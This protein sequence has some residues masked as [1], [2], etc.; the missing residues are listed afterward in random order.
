MKKILDKAA[1][2]FS[3][4]FYKGL[5]REQSIEASYD[6][7]YNSIQRNMPNIEI[8]SHIAERFRKI[9][10]LEEDVSKVV[11]EPLKIILKR[12]TVQENKSQATKLSVNISSEFEQEIIEEGNRKRY[13]D[14]LR[15]V[16]DRFGQTTI[17]RE[18]PISEFEYRQR[19]TL[20][21]KVQDFWI[22]GFLKPSLY[23]NTAVDKKDESPEQI[24]RPLDN[25][26]VIPFDIDQSYDELQQTDIIGQISDGKT[27]LILG[28]PGSGKTIALL[29]LAERLVE[30]TQKDLNERKQKSSK[31]IPV[32]LNLSSWGQKQQPLEEWLTIS[33][34]AKHR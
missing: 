8:V 25:L 30:Q 29:Q 3:V 13:Y 2:Y 15:D 32:V 22:E 18:K 10:V 16:L 5:V 31:P 12:K 9:E 34:P 14:K 21:N 7:G 33:P 4:G 6:W 24:L 1:Y 28:E 20:L 23:F 26:E 17:E 27:L 11:S 19:Q